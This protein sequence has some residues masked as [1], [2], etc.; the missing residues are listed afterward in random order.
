MAISRARAN[1]E[2]LEK[3]AEVEALKKRAARQAVAKQTG[4][5][6]P[7]EVVTCRVLK[8]GDGKISMGVHLAGVG[9]AFYEKGEEFDI[10]RSIADELEDRGF[11]EIKDAPKADA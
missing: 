4:E 9:D 8:N 6:P 7:P 11:V 5:I 3:Q 2:A 1:A 10:E